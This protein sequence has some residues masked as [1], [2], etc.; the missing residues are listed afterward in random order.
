VKRISLLIELVPI[1][2]GQSVR[3]LASPSD[4]DV[5]ALPVGSKLSLVPLLR[6][7]NHALQDQVLDL[8]FPRLHFLVVHGLDLLFICCNAD[9][10]MS[11]FL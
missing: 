6:A 9:L 5:G 8:K 10:G 2:I 3:P 1:L 11:P 7:L 4:D